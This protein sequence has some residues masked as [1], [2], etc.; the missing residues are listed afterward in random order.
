M[1]NI[2][3]VR[4]LGRVMGRGAKYVE[5]VTMK[6]RST[7]HLYAYS[8]SVG[9]FSKVIVTMTENMKPDPLTML[10]PELKRVIHKAKINRYRRPTPSTFNLP[11]RNDR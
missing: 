2:S 8:C 7:S 5:S 1:S 6:T 9:T 10:I 3:N 4:L 11:T